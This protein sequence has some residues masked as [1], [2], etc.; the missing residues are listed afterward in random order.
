[1]F[2]MSPITRAL[3]LAFF[4]FAGSTGASAQTGVDLAG[5]PIPTLPRFETTDL[6]RNGDALSVALDVRRLGTAPGRDVDVY[7]CLARSAEEWAADPK[8][9]DVR[10]EGK[11]TVAVG[12]GGKVTTVVELAGPGELAAD[13]G[14]T[15]GKAYDIVVDVDRDGRLSPKDVVDGL[16]DGVGFWRLGSLAG[17]GPQSVKRGEVEVAGR[18][19]ATFIPDRPQGR[20]LPLVVLGLDGAADSAA[21]RLASVLASRGLAVA[22]AGLRIDRLTVA[23]I[24][25]AAGEWIACT[26]G[27]LMRRGAGAIGDFVDPK[28]IGWIGRAALS[29]VLARAY[30]RLIRGSTTVE[31]FDATNIALLGFLGSTNLLGRTDLDTGLGA[32][33]MLGSAMDLHAAGGSPQARGIAVYERARGRKSLLLLQDASLDAALVGVG[34]NPQVEA[35]VDT[36]LSAAAAVYLRG[37]LAGEAI[38]KK[39]PEA[40]RLD[41]LGDAPVLFSEFRE[42][43]LARNFVIDD[44]ET[45]RSLRMA[46]SGAAIDW[47]VK[48][49]GEAILADLGGGSAAAP[50]ALGRGLARAHS[51]DPERWVT[52]FDW[53][54][55]PPAHYRLSLP[56]SLHDLRDFSHLAMRAAQV[57]RHPRT[58][59]LDGP[60]DF[61]VSLIDSQG[62]TVSIPIAPFAR[63]PRPSKVAASVASP[64]A[65]TEFMS[66]RLRLDDFTFGESKLDIR[67]VRFLRLDFGAKYGSPTGCLAVDDIELVRRN[68][69]RNG[70]DLQFENGVPTSLAPEVPN[71]LQVAVTSYGVEAA[72]DSFA[73]TV[74]Y[75]D[76]PPKRIALFGVEGE[77]SAEL[78]PPHNARLAQFYLDAADL[79]GRQ[80]TLP[81]S[82]P[83]NYF[84]VPVG[85][86]DVLL[87][88]KLDVD[89][90]FTRTGAWEFGKPEGK[91]GAGAGSHPDPSSGYTGT[92]VFGT[93]LSGDV[94]ASVETSWLTLPAVDLLDCVAAKVSYRRRL[95]ADSY[96]AAIA[97]IQSSEDGGDTWR[98]AWAGSAVDTEWVRHEVELPKSVG[99]RRQVVVRFGYRQRTGARADSG[100]NIDDVEISAVRFSTTI[101]GVR[102]GRAAAGTYPQNGPPIA[103]LYING[104]DGGEARRVD[105]EV[106]KAV[107]IAVMQPETNPLPANFA[108]F[109]YL[110]IPWGG[111]A[112]QLPGVGEFLFPPSPTDVGNTRLFTLSSSYSGAPLRGTPNPGAQAPWVAMYGPVLFPVVATVQ[113]L[114]ES[115]PGQWVISNAVLINVVP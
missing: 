75:D 87:G 26:E 94:Q 24:D 43:V 53:A 12:V 86:R 21:E 103:L 42:S 5:R 110:G 3:S 4:A 1:M 55:G 51:N 90:G 88:T 109:G 33:V 57:A 104:S 22:L 31:S 92:N 56:P 63:L 107:K 112:T 91:G 93:A 19:L 67:D 83:L 16:G 32:M 15:L 60:L 9:G 106:G 72:R 7:V 100:W 23:G 114:I 39:C 76:A 79:Q 8:L 47:N 50:D 44:H 54:P 99:G 62:R 61:S 71:L 14:D 74:G 13:S 70:L 69:T 84:E 96:P 29:E 66:I 48:N 38:L 2:F 27:L 68:A 20:R 59:A 81:A 105:C 102:L 34:S 115:Q 89:P 101:E 111:Q 77:Y 40:F 73:I 17:M 52:V 113:A 98:D 45:R 10:A 85:N 65:Q 30:T 36:Y 28:R 35:V 6:F 49:V 25:Q 78:T 95:H 97:V 108:V 41:G 82:A 64:G 46:S 11:T 37:D 80:Y 18:R 58:E